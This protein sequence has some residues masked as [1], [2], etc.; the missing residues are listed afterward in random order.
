MLHFNQ[1]SQTPLATPEWEN[2]LDPCSKTDY[3]L[4][5]ILHNK[6]ANDK[7]LDSVTRCFLTQIQTN[8]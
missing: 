3:E 4:D 2:K 1:A 5:D 6:L 7:N 8:I